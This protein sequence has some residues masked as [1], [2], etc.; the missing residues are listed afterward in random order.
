MGMESCLK[1]V[2]KAFDTLR[3]TK[4]VPIC[5]NGCYA[6]NDNTIDA[7]PECLTQR[8]RNRK[9][10]VILKT[11]SIL[12]KVA[13]LLAIDSTREMIREYRA[14]FKNDHVYRDVFSGEMY[15]Q[16]KEEFLGEHDVL[17]GLCVDGFSSKNSRESLTMIHA[18]V[19]SI[20]PSYRFVN[21]VFFFFFF[22]MNTLI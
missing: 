6:F 9:K 10:G 8:P 1:T 13:Q 4:E 2:K 14:N 22:L 15:A 3:F 21:L 18:I 17:I 12:D 16:L 7:C 20:D 5:Q 11:V 19:F